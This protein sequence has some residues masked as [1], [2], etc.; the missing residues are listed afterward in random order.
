[1]PI[2][3]GFVAGW[4][5]GAFA[6]ITITV[7]APNIKSPYL[8]FLPGILFGLGAMTIQMFAGTI[9]GIFAARKNKLSKDQI[10]ETTYKTSARTLLVG[11]MLF[12]A[13]GLFGLLF[14]SITS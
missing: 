4:G 2:V 6:I 8:A 14:P 1:M 5:V 3:H 7:L 11:G 13:A 10:K 9:F 12:M